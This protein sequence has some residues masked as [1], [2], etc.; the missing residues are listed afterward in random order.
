V[1][2]SPSTA[3][4]YLKL[5]QSVDDHDEQVVVVE[6]ACGAAEN[7]TKTDGVTKEVFAEL[8][9]TGHFP[10]CRPCVSIWR[11]EESR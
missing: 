7:D 8:H 6:T 4:H 10:L 11:D 9:F 3:I 2:T 1:R 5:S